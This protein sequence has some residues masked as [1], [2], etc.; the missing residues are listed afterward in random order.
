MSRNPYDYRLP[1]QE[2]DRFFG[3]SSELH[4]AREII[5]NKACLSFVGEPHCGL[6]SLLRRLATPDFR[7]Q[8]E[9][10]TGQL[11]FVL[12]DCVR[13]NEPLLIIRHILSETAP[14]QPIPNVPN[15]RSLQGRLIR[16]LGRLKQQSKRVVILFD[17][18]EALGSREGSL[19]FLESLRAVAQS[20]VETTLI[21]ATRTELKNCCHIDVLKSPF[22][23]IFQ[24]DYVGAFSSEEAAEF[25]RATSERS[26]VDLVPYAQQILALGNCFP[27]FL[28][29]ACALYFGVV[30]RG[31]EPDHADLAERFRQEATPAFDVIW[32]RLSESEK[33]VLSTLA[34]DSASRAM[35][36]SLIDKGY[37][38]DNRIFSV[39]FE[40]YLGRVA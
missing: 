27:Y 31:D 18:F 24:A 8:C 36:R 39:A 40:G 20:M 26:G 1:V 16:V 10:V 30:S 9:D 23:N 28:Q 29:M 22:P 34:E 15:W 14:E 4:R 38:V 21:T 37:I 12:V 25:L 7:R 33:R 2:P 19:D 32:K 5:Q 35:E 13:L 6:S 11:L 3:R 17:D